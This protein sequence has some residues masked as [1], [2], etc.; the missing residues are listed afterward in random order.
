MKSVPVISALEILIGI[1]EIH[2]LR[3]DQK[4][5]GYFEK[6]KICRSW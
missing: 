1:K 5:M 3:D 2:S 6:K 4:V